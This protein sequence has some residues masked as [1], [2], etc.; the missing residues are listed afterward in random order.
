MSTAQ[1]T[2][3]KAT[4]RRFC[5]A[6]NSGDAELIS[7]TIDELV[8][9]DAVIPSPSPIEATGAQLLKEVFA[10]LHRAFSDLHTTIGDRGPGRQPRH[11]YR[12]PLGRNT[13]VSRHRANPSRTTRSPSSASRVDESRRLGGS[14]TSSRR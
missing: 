3:N 1:R 7:K 6:A 14:S 2:S 11:G 5:D 13:W 12:D 4:I 8:E 9:P 10:R